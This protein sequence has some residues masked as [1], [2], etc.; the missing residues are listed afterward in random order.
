MFAATEKGGPGS[1][2]DFSCLEP[3]KEIYLAKNIENV[4]IQQG[5]F[6]DYLKVT[7]ESLV[8]PLIFAENRPR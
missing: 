7:V 8:K 3:D 6:S 4:Y 1:T 2:K 5:A